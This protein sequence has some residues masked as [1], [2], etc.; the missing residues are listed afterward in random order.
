MGLGAEQRGPHG[1]PVAVGASPLANGTGPSSTTSV[2]IAPLPC[3]MDTTLSWE[4]FLRSRGGPGGP[5]SDEPRPRPD[6]RSCPRRPHSKS[7]GRRGCPRTGAGAC[8]SRSLTCAGDAPGP[9]PAG[10][11]WARKGSHACHPPGRASLVS[12]LW[13]GSVFWLAGR[14]DVPAR[15]GEY[16]QEVP[17]DEGP[18]LGPDCSEEA[19]RG[20]SRGGQFTAKL[21]RPQR[22]LT[23]CPAH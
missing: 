9:G 15:A 6:L 18:T 21:W 22:P 3:S 17:Q 2:G 1:V 8:L 4:Q 12:P 5:G 13:S 16:V 14:T 11:F 23:S 19:P 7:T 20:S 10:H